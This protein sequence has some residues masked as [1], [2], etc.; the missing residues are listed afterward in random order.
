MHPAPSGFVTMA[1]SDK[2]VSTLHAGVILPIHAI[3]V[4]ENLDL[5][6]TF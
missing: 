3:Y 5:R 1:A 2:A 6:V 4:N